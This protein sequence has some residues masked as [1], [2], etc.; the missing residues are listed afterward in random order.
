MGLTLRLVVVQLTLTMWSV[1]LSALPFLV[2]FSTLP[3]AKLQLLGL[4]CA[5]LG[6]VAHIFQ[7]QNKCY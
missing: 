5:L 3:C 6:W 7:I 1:G 4:V 2:E